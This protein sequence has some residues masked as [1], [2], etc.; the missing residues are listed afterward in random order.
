MDQLDPYHDLYGPRARMLGSR[1][2][3][4]RA[5]PRP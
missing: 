3:Q 5:R 4:L 2:R 1:R